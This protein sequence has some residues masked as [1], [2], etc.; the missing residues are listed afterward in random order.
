MTAAHYTHSTLRERIAE[1]VFVGDALRTLWRLGIGKAYAAFG[2]TK[3]SH[4]LRFR[5]TALSNSNLLSSRY[6]KIL[7]M[8]PLNHGEDYPTALGTSLLGFSTGS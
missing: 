5:E 1:H 3:H 6:E 4:D 7:L 2:L 8:Q